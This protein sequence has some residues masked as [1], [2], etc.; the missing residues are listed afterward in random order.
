MKVY[1]I[2]MP[3]AGKSTLGRELATILNYAF[4]DL[5]AEIEKVAS[6]TIPQIFKV[7]GE[8]FFRELESK[9]LK[10]LSF[11]AEKAVIATGGGTPCF[12]NN[13]EFMNAHGLTIYLM[14]SPDTLA[15]RL[16]KTDLA[17]RP[18][19][20]ER[21]KDDLHHFLAET[22]VN[23]A[24]FY[25]QAGIVFESRSLTSDAAALAQII[26]EDQNLIN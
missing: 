17:G 12:Y 18:L 22:L 11:S 13:L 23:R 15:N 6:L 14:A 24:T 19:F 26:R 2:G 8:A 9:I 16:I 1:L 7:N 25:E 10:T 21:T 3:G 4:F 5:D 20:Q